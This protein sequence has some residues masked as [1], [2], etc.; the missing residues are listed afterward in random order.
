MT[1]IIELSTGK[2]IELTPEEYEELVKRETVY[3]RTPMYQGWLPSPWFELP[4]VV[5]YQH[6]TTGGTA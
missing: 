2:K 4:P 1:L 3:V 5:S 6:Q